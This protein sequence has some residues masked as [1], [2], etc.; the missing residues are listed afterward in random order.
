[1]QLESVDFQLG[2]VNMKGVNKMSRNLWIVID[3]D[4]VQIR[5]GNGGVYLSSGSFMDKFDAYKLAKILSKE[6]GLE[7]KEE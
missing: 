4:E 2:I 1:V 5:G 3:F 6:T 7:I